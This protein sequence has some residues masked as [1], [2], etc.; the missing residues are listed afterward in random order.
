MRRSFDSQPALFA[1]PALLDHP[2]LQA[3]DEVEWLIDWSRLEPLLPQGEGRTGRPGWPAMTLFRALLLGLWHDLSDVQLEAQLARDLV[4]RRFC[5]LELDQAPPQASTLGRFR[6]A[7]EREGRLQTLLEEINAGLAGAGVVLEEGR[8]AIVDATVV[9]AAR[10]RR[11]TA[12]PEAGSR[13]KLDGQGRRRAVWGWQ[14]FVNSDED[15]FIHATA[16]SPGNR[17]EIRSLPRVITGGESQLYADAAY[18]AGW[19]R[20]ALGRAGVADRVQRKGYRNRPLDAADRARNKEIAVTRGRVEAI[21]GALK[22]SWGLARTR[23]LGEARNAAQLALTAIAWNL[24]K[25]A[26]LRRSGA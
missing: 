23:F 20:R 9:E 13:V 16:L 26:T 19:V 15:G 3:L 24:R 1:T 7:L 14:A 22:R 17:H 21:F 11:S 18:S 12:D 6:M 10:S 25:G 5:R 8:V 2:A 4:F